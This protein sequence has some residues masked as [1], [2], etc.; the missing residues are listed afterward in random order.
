[1]SRALLSAPILAVSLALAGCSIGT[2][3]L[4]IPKLEEE[5][6]SGVLEQAGLD[7]SVECP[8]QVDIEAGKSFE[9]EV[10]PADG[11]A[12]ATAEVTMEDE[13]GNITWELV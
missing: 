7:V 3:E 6:G 11:G 13:D 10:T 4:D 1:M 8:D 5:I 9:C 2:S 12:A